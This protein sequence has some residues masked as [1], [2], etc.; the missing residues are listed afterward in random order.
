M[1]DRALTRVHRV[2]G[3]RSLLVSLVLAALVVATAEWRR[4]IGSG[5]EPVSAA[6]A[7][8][9]QA[10][11]IAQKQS[12]LQAVARDGRLPELSRAK[13]DA[14]DPDR[15]ATYDSGDAHRPGE[16]P[17]HLPPTSYSPGGAEAGWTTVNRGPYKPWMGYQEQISGAQ[18]AA[19]GHVFEYHI[20]NPR[21]GKVVRFDGHT[22]RGQERQEVFLD[23]KHGYRV[24]VFK[25]DLEKAK[26]MRINLVTEA[27]RQLGTL[28]EEAVL[29]WHCS[30]PYAAQEIR[31]ILL[32][33]GLTDVDV[34]YTPEA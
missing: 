8:V 15:G 21:T 1:S 17:A 27:R 7:P 18:R 23:A 19:D 3:R 34:N 16:H 11:G 14:F 2:A 4:R 22:Y 29:E 10:S 28:P 5:R 6:H 20:A 25:P 31:R 9:E 30:D 13:K 32:R 24:I 33:E 12:M 26:A